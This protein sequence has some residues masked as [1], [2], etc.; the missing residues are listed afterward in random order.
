MSKNGS[1]AA[2]GGAKSRRVP[3]RPHRSYGFPTRSHRSY[4]FLA[5]SLLLFAL[6]WLLNC[7]TVLGGFVFDDN[8]AIVTNPDI[9]YNVL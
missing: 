4:G 3:A 9:R 1:T 5:R 7:H 8:E 6:S 2:A